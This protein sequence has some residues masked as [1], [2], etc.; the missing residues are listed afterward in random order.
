MPGDYRPGCDMR[1]A[2][3]LGTYNDKP[4]ISE[5]NDC[6]PCDFTEEVNS[7]R[8]GCCEVGNEDCINVKKINFGFVSSLLVPALFM[9]S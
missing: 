6:I 1:I 4:E 7:E 5:A 2:C 3:Q 9:V 8:T